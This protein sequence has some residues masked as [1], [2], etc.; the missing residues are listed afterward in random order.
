MSTSFF[1]RL[2]IPIGLALLWNTGRDA[3]SA[4]R[5][6]T[7]LIAMAPVVTNQNGQHGKIL[8]GASIKEVE[9]GELGV[10]IFW[11]ADGR[12]VFSVLDET[13]KTPIMYLVDTQ[14]I[15]YNALN[16]SV[17]YLSD[18][19]FNF[20]LRC[21][22]GKFAYGFG[23]GQGAERC[24][25]S[26]DVRSFYNW[27]GISDQIEKIAKGQYRFIRKYEKDRSFAAI[28][29][30]QR[31]CPYEQ[32]Y[33]VSGKPDVSPLVVR[34]LAVDSDV[35][36]QTPAFPKKEIIAK[37][38]N[39]LDAELDPEPQFFNLEQFMLEAMFARPAIRNKELR[40]DFEGRHGSRL[41]PKQALYIN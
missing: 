34:K 17:L 2:S 28:V 40:R 12:R 36:F 3:R 23:L 11:D 14:A 19:S 32:L 27:S 7:E 22:E 38:C 25:I 35:H 6:A 30:T 29:D 5:S 26:V 4:E 16:A 31:R 1:T 13:D 10:R 9:M 33:L 8:I 18:A 39:L 24:D 20:R 15:I 21:K 37:S 41:V